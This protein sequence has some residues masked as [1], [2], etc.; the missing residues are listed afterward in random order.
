[1]L[2]VNAQG[3]CCY[4]LLL[5]TSPAPE[6]HCGAFTLE[7]PPHFGHFTAG[8]PAGTL[9]CCPQNPHATVTDPSAPVSCAVDVAFCIAA[10]P[11]PP[12]APLSKKALIAARTSSC[13]AM[14]CDA[15]DGSAPVSAQN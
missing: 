7:T 1:V 3:G 6:C 4:F 8:V 2:M 9:K 15:V 10:P 13:S 14:N 12:S 5:T 11:P